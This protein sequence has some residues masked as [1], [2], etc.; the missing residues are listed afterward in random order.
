ML[1]LKLYLYLSAGGKKIKKYDFIATLF[2]GIF[3]FN[4]L[5]NVIFALEMT[6]LFVV[7]KHFYNPEMP[8][9]LFIR[10]TR[11]ILLRL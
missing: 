9:M 4:L 3:D 10:A 5:R 8:A 11:I 7:I 1:R 2:S 6:A